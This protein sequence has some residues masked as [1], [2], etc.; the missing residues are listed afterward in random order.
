[1]KIPVLNVSI[2][3]IQNQ[4]VW[5]GSYSAEIKPAFSYIY[6]ISNTYTIQAE[7]ETWNPRKYVKKIHEGKHRDRQVFLYDTQAHTIT[8]PS[9]EKTNF[10]ES[11]HS[12]FSAMLWIQHHEWSSGESRTEIV[13][14]D[15]QRWQIQ[16]RVLGTEVVNPFGKKVQTKVVEAQLVQ[17]I[18]GEK[19]TGRTD[20]LSANIATKDRTL[21]FWVDISTD[22]IYRIYVPM[23]PFS[24]WAHL[25]E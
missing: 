18:G 10:P 9:G 3:T 6:E 13:E 12:L 11:T 25:K 20:Y 1:M 14:I 16:L 2:S 19:M 7:P 15:G 17:P 24:V 5:T 21:R 8:L 4:D 23:S 22:T